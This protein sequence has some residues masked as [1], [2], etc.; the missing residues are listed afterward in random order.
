[1]MGSIFAKTQE[2]AAPKFTVKDEKTGLDKLMVKYRGQASKEFQ[3]EFYGGIKKGT[4]AE[5]VA[6]AAPCTGSAQDVIDNY[7]GSLR[8]ALTY[9]GSKDIKE[10]QRKAEFVRSTSSFM[11]VCIFIV[12]IFFL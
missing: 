1:M 8:S 2:S 7:C 12:L 5:G 6:F 10:L 9:G 4:V 3:Q 11:K